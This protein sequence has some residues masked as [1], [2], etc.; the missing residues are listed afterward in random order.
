MIKSKNMPVLL[1]FL[2]MIYLF[3][4]ARLYNGDDI[5]YYAATG[6][7][8]F[9]TGYFYDFTMIPHELPIT[10]QNGMGFIHY[11]LMKIGFTD[12]MNRIAILW[13]FG[14][15]IYIFILLY[16]SKIIDLVF[17]SINNKNIE[18]ILLVL[19]LSA[20]LLNIVLF[21]LND[22]LYLLFS[23]ILIYYSL[24]YFFEDSKKNNRIMILVLVLISLFVGILF[25]I[26]AILI[27]LV[28]LFISFFYN[29]KFK[30]KILY[31]ANMLI[32]LAL[33]YFI[34]VITISDF[35]RIYLMKE[36]FSLSLT[37]DNFFFSISNL[38]EIVIPSLFLQFNTNSFST[39]TLIL[40]LSY[41][42]SILVLIVVFYA[43]FKAFKYK[44]Y[45][46]LTLVFIVIF[47]FLFLFQ[48]SVQIPRYIILFYP[49]FFIILLYVFDTKKFNIILYVYLI[50][51]F[52]I[53]IIRCFFSENF[54]SNKLNTSIINQKYNYDIVI[55]Y[56]TR[57]ASFIFQQ[58]VYKNI[59]NLDNIK[60]KTILI[61][62]DK[63]Y[64]N[65]ILAGLSSKGFKYTVI[66]TNIQFKTNNKNSVL[67]TFYIRINNE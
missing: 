34:Q 51:L 6:E 12:I 7:S 14:F 26:Q 17:H 54:S 15:V 45:K 60:N 47:N 64:L 41:L 59:K 25:R 57:M 39:Y 31:F 66:D 30:V 8:L 35:S 28:F 33:F 13:I 55:S 29:I 9:Y 42:I 40:C 50:Y 46:V 22:G 18:I 4:Y 11:F 10:T 61:L 32:S 27:P 58:R 1:I 20:Y 21:P 38:L 3:F 2:Y 44:N 52:I 67:N 65:R 63:E 56:H 23:L 49:L 43:L 48:F 53:F 37:I 36:T 16:I 24:I 19:S 5:Y 62:G